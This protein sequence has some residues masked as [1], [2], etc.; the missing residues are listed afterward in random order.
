[1]TYSSV[2]SQ[3]NASPVPVAEA[4]VEP[5]QE[6]RG[7]HRGP[8][9]GPVE[10][11]RAAVSRRRRRDGRR[12]RSGAGPDRASAGVPPRRAASSVDRP[13]ASRTAASAR[14]ALPA[15]PAIRPQF[16]SRPWTAALTSDDETTARAT[17][18]ASASST[19]PET[20]HVIERR[21]ALAVGRLLAGEVARDG[22]DRA[23]QLASP[24]ACPALTGAAP[25]A[26]EA[27]R[28]TVSFVLVS[29]STLSW[30]HV[31]AAAGRSSPWSVGRVDRRVGQDDRE[32]RRHPRVD[33]PDALGDAGDPDRADREAVGIGQGDRHGRGLRPRVGRP[34]GLRGRG[35]PRR[36]MPRGA[37]RARRCRRRPC[38]AAAACR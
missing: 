35:E 32:H 25:A 7:V 30:S 36:R 6:L 21:R 5:D 12:S 20:W 31:R 24:R 13:A 10:R 18:R 28:N 37:A 17:A 16:G 34:E 27:S 2:R 26:P 4:E 15:A 22:L 33:H 14:R 8:G 29:P 11:D 19:A 38:R 1:M 9:G 3:P 23:P